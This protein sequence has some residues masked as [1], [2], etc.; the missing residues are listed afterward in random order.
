VIGVVGMP[1]SGKSVVDDVAK[2]LGFSIVI[3]GDIIR[4][5]VVKRGLQPTS[6]NMSKMMLQIRT[7]EGQAA[8]AKKCIPKIINA[9]SQ[10]II[11]DGIRSLA[12]VKL[13][14]QTFHNFKLLTIHS[15]PQTRFHRLFN[16]KRSDDPSDW[17]LFT[18]RDSREFK[19]GIGPVIA[20]ADYVIQ[21]EESLRRF[22]SR[23]RS[24]L[25]ATKN[26]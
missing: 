17:K 2:N 16:R 19:V 4:A 20:I 7:E 12:E 10:D 9:P 3:M 22:K 11:V 1:G 14:K 23:V 6:E 8:V 26:E 24:F 21:N 13:F 18:D 5:E 15:S 25:K